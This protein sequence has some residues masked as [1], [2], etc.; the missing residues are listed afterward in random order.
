MSRPFD[1]VSLDEAAAI[2]GCTPSTVRRHILAG[3]LTRHRGRYKH[4]ALSRGDV[5]ALACLIYPWW[6]HTGDAG[7]YWVTGQS[8]ADVM[9]VCR[10]RLNQ[11]A[12][13]DRVPYVTHRDRTRLY[14]RQQLEVMSRR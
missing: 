12:D 13:K 14:R 8:A 7:S 11:L 3:R 4:Q 2:L 1:P 5:E 9:G 6:R 10:S